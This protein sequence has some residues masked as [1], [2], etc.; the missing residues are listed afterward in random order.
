MLKIRVPATTA[1]IGPGFDCLGLALELYNT[2]EIDY[3]VKTHIQVFGEGAGK[4]PCSEDNLVYRALF[5][6][7]EEMDSTPP[8]LVLRMTNEIPLARGLGSSAAAIVAGLLAADYL[9]GQILPREKL[10]DLAVE[11]EGHPDNVAPALLG[12][13]VISTAKSTGAGYH[14]LQLAPPRELQAVV[15][16]P[17]FLVATEEARRVL[18]VQIAFSD[19]VHNLGRVALLLGAFTSKR[20][21]LL[22]AALEDRLHQPYRKGLVPGLDRALA[23]A[24]EAGALGAALSGSGPTIIAFVKDNAAEVGQAM[25]QAFAGMDIEARN[26]VLG[27]NTRGAEALLST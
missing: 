18:P 3:G 12:G 21:D 23:R 1:N 25:K 9:T 5:R 2:L 4:L 19:A 8:P 7:Y 26:I 15:C 22:P 10:L 11:L 20:W 14:Y 16:I 24:M 13:L 27:F 6:Y 17:D